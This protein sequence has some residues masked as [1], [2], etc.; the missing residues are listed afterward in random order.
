MD[1]QKNNFL[2]LSAL[3][4]TQ[5]LGEFYVISLSARDLLSITFSEPL[6]YIDNSG[7]LQ[8]SQRKKDEKRLKEIATYIESVEM[9]FPNAIILGANYTQNGGISKDLTERW[10]IEFD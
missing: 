1:N 6:R 2:E 3:K 8:G 9:A 10:S 5:P 7:T 4:V